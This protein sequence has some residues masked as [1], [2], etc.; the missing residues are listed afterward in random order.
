MTLPAVMA[1]LEAVG[2]AQNV[3]TYRRHGVTGP[4]FGASFAFLNGFAK[5]IGRDHELATALWVTGNFDAMHLAVMIADPS[6]LT[7]D[8][9]DRWLEGVVYHAAAGAL[10][11]VVGR[12]PVGLSRAKAW[13][14]HPADLTRNTGYDTLVVLVKEGADLD[15]AWLAGVVAK[16]EAEVGTSGNRAR[17][18]MN[19]ALIA[20]GGYRADLRDVVIATA[21]R[22]GTIEVDHGDTWCLTPDIVPYIEKIAARAA[23]KTR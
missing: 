4:I 3:E 19:Q 1:S 9:A 17:Y 11:G 20:I 22:I 13:I 23:R 2:T 8:E 10:C 15:A 21:R 18:A 6:G 5:K 7:D 14:E 12:S 16:I